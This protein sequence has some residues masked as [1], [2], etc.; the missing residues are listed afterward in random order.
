MSRFDGLRPSSAWFLIVLGVALAAGCAEAPRPLAA[1]EVRGQWHFDG[2]TILD[3]ARRET[4]RE[5]ADPAQEARLLALADQVGAG[6]RITFEADGTWE[7]QSISTG[8]NTAR[9]TA[10]FASLLQIDPLGP[11]AAAYYG[12]H[13]FPIDP[14]R[15]CWGAWMIDAQGMVHYQANGH[16]GPAEHQQ[17]KGTGVIRGTER[18]IELVQD[19]SGASVPLLRAAPPAGS[20]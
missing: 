6:Y 8:D 16:G 10:L 12:Q 17:I 13:R 3:H 11:Q 20:H 9:E 4:G 19:G 15:P 2:K 14:K 5:P 1:S 7:L 18:G